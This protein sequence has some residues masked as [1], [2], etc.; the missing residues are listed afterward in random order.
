MKIDYFPWIR[1]SLLSFL[2]LLFS[3]GG[4]A[5][6]FGES[7]ESYLKV[8]LLYGTTAVERITINSDTG[9]LLGTATESGFSETLPLQAYQSLIVSVR[10]GHVAIED[11][12]GVLL[13]ADIGL[14]GCIWPVD[15]EGFFSLGAKK[16]RGGLVF[17]VNSGN[18]INVI[19]YLTMDEY[20]YGVLHKEMS[21]SNP[22]EALKAQAV[23]ARSFATENVGRHAADG[24]DL[25][26]T[27]HCQVYDGIQSEY[28][29]TITAVDDT[30][31]LTLWY[32]GTPV[33]A[34]Y[35]KNSGGHTQSVQDVWSSSAIPYLTGVSDPYSPLYSWT[36]TVTFESMQQKLL[37]ANQD[38][39]T[40]QSVKVMERNSAGA[41]SKLA[42]NGSKS[43]VTLAK[44][45]I[46]SILGTT[47]IRSRHF[48]LGESAPV[49]ETTLLPSLTISNGR[50]KKTDPE[51]VYIISSTGTTKAANSLG[52]YLSNGKTTS[53]VKTIQNDVPNYDDSYVAS[54][55]KV[56]FN[57]NGYG[58]GV[59]M[60]QDGAIE[61]A[62]QG[63]TFMDILTFYFQDIE[64][65]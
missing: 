20:L 60:S 30:S 43:T 36:A 34:Y 28:P 25:C 56:V 49:S 37:L 61:M 57:G 39:G 35:H 63:Y 52:L 19:N 13:S 44:E 11:T 6:A 41:V 50:S 22:L 16:Y 15:N 5:V 59:G 62:K 51:K 3:I 24:F 32:A 38:V 40:I 53:Q 7:D 65:R 10:D 4:T 58:H 42:V 1:T 8:G 33:V 29:S 26:S 31:G 17:R 18:T 2:V 64:V 45:T 21:Q 14:S 46:R 55:G 47:L 9:F 54:D 27:V 12:N 48:Y 23:A